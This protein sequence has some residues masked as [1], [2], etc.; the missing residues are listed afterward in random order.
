MAYVSIPTYSR[1]IP[2]RYA[3]IGTKC[4]SCSVVNFPRTLS[5]LKCGRADFEPLKLSGR[6]RIYCYTMISRGGSPP[7]FSMQQNLVGSY[8]VAVIELEEGPK[9]VAQMADCKPEE[10]KIGLPVEATF[11]RIYEDDGIIRYGMK[12]RPARA[13]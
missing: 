5:C 6:G 4:K 7:E 9:I 8:H 3:L 10:L 11:R 2:Q 13:G 12:F 1:S